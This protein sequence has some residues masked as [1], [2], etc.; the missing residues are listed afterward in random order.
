MIGDVEPNAGGNGPGQDLRALARQC[1]RS[2]RGLRR[3]RAVVG[4][5]NFDF[6][7]IDSPVF[8]VR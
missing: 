2:G 4:F 5:E 7:A 6:P 1:G 3:I 8:S